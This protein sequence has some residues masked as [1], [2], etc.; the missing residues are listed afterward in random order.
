VFEPFVARVARSGGRIELAQLVLKLTAPGIPDIFQGDELPRR[1][2]VDPDNRRPVD[3]DFYQAMLRRLMGGSPP[4][5]ETYKMFLTLRLLGLRARAPE[6]F[7]GSYEPLDAGDGVCA[8]LR[9][10]VVLVAVSV[11]GAQLAESIELPRGRWRDVLRGDERSFEGRTAVADVL[12]S[13]GLAVFER[14]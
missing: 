3:W 10:R 8:Y 13:L 5:P 2:L 11:G 4:D 14:L 12:D 1:T 7:A 6:A 9:G